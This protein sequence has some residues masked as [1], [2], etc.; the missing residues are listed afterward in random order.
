MLELLDIIIDFLANPFKTVYYLFGFKSIGE[1]ENLA[2][3]F[4]GE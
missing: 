3:K 1:N 2:D 4:L